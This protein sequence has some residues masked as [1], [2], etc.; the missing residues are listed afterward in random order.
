MGVKRVKPGE[1]E[2]PLQDAIL[3]A[4][5]DLVRARDGQLSMRALAEAVGIGRASLYR[6][7]ASKEEVFEALEARGWLDPD[8][9]SASARKET[10]ERILDALVVVARRRTL[11]YT[12]VREV[13]AEARVA[14][15]TLYRHFPDRKALLS[16]YARERSPLA[17]LNAL[18]TQLLGLGSIDEQLGALLI[19]LVHVEYD[20]GTQGLVGD[21]ASPMDDEDAREVLAHLRMLEA[22]ARGM[23]RAFFEMQVM[24]GTLRGD[25][26]LLTISF[27]G[28]VH[29]LKRHHPTL[30]AEARQALCRALVQQFL[31]GCLVA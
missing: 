31:R 11:R 6:S 26:S 4:A 27:T 18:P 15:I 9:G 7:Y 24:S 1:G 20:H 19:E 2:G 16:S 14:E 21:L 30:D 29:G 5:A 25:V 3:M 23:L 8:G 13:A 22:G 12:T 17:R 28:L 10:R